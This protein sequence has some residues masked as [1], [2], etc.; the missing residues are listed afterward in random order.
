MD[1]LVAEQ[2][3]MSFRAGGFKAANGSFAISPNAPPSM[4]FGVLAVFGTG[5]ELDLEAPRSCGR[6]SG[7]TFQ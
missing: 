7:F 5:S 3:P 1:N 4:I 2:P 6:D